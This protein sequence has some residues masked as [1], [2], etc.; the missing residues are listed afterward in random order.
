MYVRTMVC[1][2][3]QKKVVE[4]AWCQPRITRCI[5]CGHVRPF[6]S[7]RLGAFDFCPH[8][9]GFYLRQWTAATPEVRR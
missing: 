4:C 3:H 6:G 5:D 8:C 9:V 2:A 7:G 1:Q